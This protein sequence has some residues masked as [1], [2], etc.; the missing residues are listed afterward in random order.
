MMP[1]RLRCRVIALESDPA[2]SRANARGGALFLFLSLLTLLLLLTRP[3]R[4][5]T[6]ASLQVAA[7]VV[8]TEP[9][10]SA[11][12]LTAE[13]LRKPVAAVRQSVLAQV[14]VTAAK[15]EQET[16]EPRRVRVD[17]LRN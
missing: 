2:H 12:A 8:S 11:L 17:F 6:G 10:R 16:P 7:R 15:P 5:Q 9:S 14:T 13:V 1:Q 4:A 3:V